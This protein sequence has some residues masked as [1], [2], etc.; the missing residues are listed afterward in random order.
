MWEID[1]QRMARLVPA[2]FGLFVIT[3]GSAH[4]QEWGFSSPKGAVVNVFRDSSLNMSGTLALPPNE[5]GA[6]VTVPVTGHNEPGKLILEFDDPKTGAGQTLTYQRKKSSDGAYTVWRAENAPE[7]LS[8][9]RA[10]INVSSEPAK[11]ALESWSG[12]IDGVV[13]VETYSKVLKTHWKASGKSTA[14]ENRAPT[15]AVVTD[16]PSVAAWDG[17]ASRIGT[18]ITSVQTFSRDGVIFTMNA[19][20][21]VAA[22]ENETDLLR[23]FGGVTKAASRQ[24]PSAAIP[25]STLQNFR[26]YT[27]PLANMFDT[28]AVE[29]S[30]ISK[31]EKEIEDLFARLHGRDLECSIGETATGSF[32]VGCLHHCGSHNLRGNFLVNTTFTF[33]VGELRDKA[34]QIFVMTDSWAATARMDD[35]T[36]GQD[37]FTYHRSDQP[38]VATAH[39]IAL[40]ALREELRDMFKGLR[41]D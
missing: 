41:G 30:N 2:L 35:P 25:L 26:A 15:V 19:N 34:R 22:L 29:D 7:A 21:L 1:M 38:V 18:N 36:P 16:R 33:G 27:V 13:P 20:D 3:T 5:N 4:S 10:P 8:E 23:E 9:L 32:S 12:D 37:R 24:R 17:A 40:S 14:E 31:I 6:Q 11:T 39:D 28:Y